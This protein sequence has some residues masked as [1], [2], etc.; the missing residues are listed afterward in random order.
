M[1]SRA[2]KL[3]VAGMLIDDGGRVLITRR[4]DDQPL[5]GMWEFPGG[6]LEPGEAPTDGLARE[7]REELGVDV[8]WGGRGTCCTT[9]TR[10]S[11]C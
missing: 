10:S 11:T 5:G 2:R 9:R 8:W 1:T 6:K 4:R 7:L 3:V